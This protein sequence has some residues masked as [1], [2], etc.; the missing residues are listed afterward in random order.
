MLNRIL[1][2]VSIIG[3]LLLFFKLIRRLQLRAARGTYKITPNENQLLYFSSAACSQCLT[4]EKI[5]Q[6]V[7]EEPTFTDIILKKYS[8]EEN[9]ALARQWKVI[10][11]PTTILLSKQ[12]DVKQF[13][14]GLIS[15]TTLRSQ[16]SA[17]KK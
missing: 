8:I 6:Q 9:S 12:G 13:N 16:F 1:I 3:A 15:A 2:A 10:T 7:F 14:N 5:L 17:L 11:L 4:Q